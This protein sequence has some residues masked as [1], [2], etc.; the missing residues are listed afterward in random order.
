VKSALLPAKKV[1]CYPN[2]TAGVTCNIRY[3]LTK[4]AQK[5]SVRIYDLAGDFVTELSG[6]SSAG[7]HEIIWNFATIQSGVYLLRVEAQTASESSV[8]FIKLAVVK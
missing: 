2:P 7:D 1:F 3:T 6:D 8:E 4:N 5:L